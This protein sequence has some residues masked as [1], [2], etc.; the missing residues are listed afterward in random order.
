MVQKCGECGT[1]KSSVMSCQWKVSASL[2]FW[3]SEY[4]NKFW[5][6]SGILTTSCWVKFNK[7]RYLHN[8][9]CS[10]K[11]SLYDFLTVWPF[12]WFKIT[13][14]WTLL[15]TICQVIETSKKGWSSS[16]QLNH[17]YAF[18]TFSYWKYWYFLWFMIICLL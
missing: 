17:R 12:S 13:S 4:W 1:E 9:L 16:S 11:Y 5:K 18:K 10:P 6:R 15:E 3:V 2:Q 8:M 14:Y 7:V